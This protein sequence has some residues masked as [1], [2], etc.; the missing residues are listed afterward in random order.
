MWFR[1]IKAAP[2]RVWAALAALAAVVLLPGCRV[3]GSGPDQAY[4]DVEG[5]SSLIAYNRVV[6]LLC[7]SSDAVLDTLFDDSLQSLADLRGLPAGAYNGGPARIK[8]LGYRDGKLVH[9]ETRVYDGAAQRVIALDTSLSDSGVAIVAGV[10]HG[11]VLDSLSGDTVVS[12]RD[13]IP[14]AARVFD[15]DGD[16][17]AYSWSCDGGPESDST[18]I[19]GY[20]VSI[21]AGSAFPDSGNHSCELK[22]WDRAGHVAKAGH[23]IRVERDPP[24]ADAGKD[25][26]VVAG[27]IIRLHA[28][29][30]DRFDAIVNREWKTAS[31]PWVRSPQ[32]ET[33]QMAPDQPGEVVFVLRIT[34][35]DGLT[36]EDTLIVTVTPA[37][38]P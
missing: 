24:T 10:P 11:P 23:S 16:L 29:G 30:D 28:K 34:D 17:A 21:A 32:Q 35:S 18:I 20:R 36:A 1:R 26:V 31:G 33:Q 4:F 3:N 12:I 38:A 15:P 6:V 19:N 14:I 22:V 9:G 27:S 5:D 7:D 37:S 2:I 8:V 25:T 13:R